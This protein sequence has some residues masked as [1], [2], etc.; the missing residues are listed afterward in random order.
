MDSGVPEAVVQAL[1]RECLRR[2]NR[3]QT[4]TKE[5]TEGD[6]TW[7]VEITAMMAISNFVTDF[8][9]FKEA[10]LLIR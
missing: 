4:H 8:S 10:C 7:S 2:E 3:E 1:E 6:R 9:P 5:E